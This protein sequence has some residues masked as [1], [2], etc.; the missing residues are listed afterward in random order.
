MEGY[1][2]ATE[3][4]ARH[5]LDYDEAAHTS[6]GDIPYQGTAACCWIMATFYNSNALGIRVDHWA[7]MIGRY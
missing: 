1:H 7:L 6:N 4:E 3:N 2:V 5:D